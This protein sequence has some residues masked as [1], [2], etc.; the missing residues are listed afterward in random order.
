MQQKEK[1]PYFASQKMQDP[2][3]TANSIEIACS[4]ILKQ[5]RNLKKANKYTYRKYH[6][7]AKKIALEYNINIDCLK[8]IINIRKE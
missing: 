8:K 5:V 6:F 7:I 4:I 1:E 2:N 3:K